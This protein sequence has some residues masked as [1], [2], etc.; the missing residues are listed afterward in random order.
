MRKV[1]NGDN[2]QFL[3][4]AMMVMASVVIV[5]YTI[6]TTSS[7]IVERVQSEYLYLTALFVILGIW[8]YLRI[9]FVENDSDSP[10]QIVLKDDYMQL[11]LLGWITSFTWIIY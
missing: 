8:G 3:D 4:G 11:T 1:L 6:F 5:A 7:E 9:A 2:L 10:T